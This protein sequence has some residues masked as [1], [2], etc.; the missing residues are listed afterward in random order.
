MKR[1]LEIQNICKFI[2]DLKVK[3]ILLTAITKLQKYTQTKEY[4]VLQ[5][6]IITAIKDFR[7][8]LPNYKI[9]LLIKTVESFF[10]VDNYEPYVNDKNK[11]FQEELRQVILCQYFGVFQI[12]I[13]AAIMFYFS[14]LDSFIHQENEF[15]K[16]YLKFSLQKCL[17][18]HYGIRSL[19]FFSFTPLKQLF[20]QNKRI[21]KFYEGIQIVPKGRFKSH[22]K[23][24]T[25]N[26][27][28][29][30]EQELVR[31]LQVIIGLYR[32]IQIFT[33]V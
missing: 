19:F 5:Q 8:R 7:R 30:F 17:S 24:M 32:E 20:T 13:G 29:M 26:I 22:F 6:V 31:I 25:F 9:V 16:V 21:V 2:Q 10:I 23:L 15:M 27:L 14:F 12:F 28:H 3:E 1:H 33:F 11:R 4:I 18:Q